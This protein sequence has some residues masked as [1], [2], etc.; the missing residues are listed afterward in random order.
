VIVDL[1]NVTFLDSSGM[2]TF[3]AARKRLTA[4]AGTLTL[5]APQ[6]QVQRAIEA[7]GLGV[8]L[9]SQ[10]WNHDAQSATC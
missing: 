3:V 1:E 8:F 9:D 2:G 7:T 10:H 4:K 5:R 6:P